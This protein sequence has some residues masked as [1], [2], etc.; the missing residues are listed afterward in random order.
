MELD[1]GNVNETINACLIL[2]N[3]L[4]RLNEPIPQRWH[5]EVENHRYDALLVPNGANRAARRVA[6]NIRNAIAQHFSDHPDV[7]DQE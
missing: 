7:V 3:L 6:I 4:E 2:H 5:R 1:I